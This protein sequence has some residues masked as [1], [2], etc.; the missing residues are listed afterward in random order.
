[1]GCSFIYHELVRWVQW[2]T[3]GFAIAHVNPFLQLSGIP[4]LCQEKT[5]DRSLHLYTQEIMK[6]TKVLECKVLVQISDMSINNFWGRTWYNYIIYVDENK[7]FMLAMII[8]KLWGVS[9]RWSK[10]KLLQFPTQPR[11][12]RSRCLLQVVESFVK[13][14]KIIW[15]LETASNTHLPQVSHARKHYSHNCHR[16]Q[17][18]DTTT[19]KTKRIVAAWTW[20]LSAI[21]ASDPRRIPR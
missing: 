11:I 14:T 15:N 13:P 9:L 12:P 7:Y 8:E 6:I 19:D 3:N 18:L 16:L 17:L 5:L 20:N 4:F 2:C 10:A 1:M 21:W